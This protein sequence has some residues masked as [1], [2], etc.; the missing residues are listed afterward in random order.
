MTIGLWGY[1]GNRHSVVN[2]L[3][4][5][6]VNLI[7][8]NILFSYLSRISTDVSLSIVWTRLIWVT[9]SLLIPAFYFFAAYFP[10]KAKVHWIFGALFTFVGLMF[11]YLSMFTNYFVSGVTI[12]AWGTQAVSGPGM[13]VFY[14]ALIT[15]VVSS[16]CMIVLK[17]FKSSQKEKR[18]IIYPIYG[19]ALFVAGNV[20][21]G[22]LLPAFLNNSKFLS[23]ADYSVLFF[24]GFTAYAIVKVRL[25]DVRFAIIR[26]VTYSLV[27]A[28]LALIYLVIAFI[29]S[30]IFNNETTS[31][32]Q[33][34]SNLSTSI[35]LAFLI[36]P[37]KRFFDKLT[38]KIFYKDR[39]HTD[40]F[41]SRLNDA[42]TLNTDLRGI[43]K[44]ASHVIASTLKCEQVFFFINTDEG[45]YVSEG[46]PHHKQLPKR[47]AEK[48]SQFCGGDYHAI[49]CSLL[50]PGNE[51][52][53][54]LERYGIEIVLPL[55]QADK[56]VGYLCLGTNLASGY[57]TRDIRV[58]NMVAD[59]MVIAVQ[60]ALAVQKI[61]ELNSTLKQ[62]INDAT[63]ELRTKNAQLKKL[64]KAKDEFVSVAAHELRTP[65]TVFRG[66]ISLLQRKGLG[67][68]TDK[69][70]EVLEKMNVN[71]KNL[72]DL[73]N[74]ML[75]LSKLEANKLVME[76]SDNSMSDLINKSL[77]KISLLYET[78]GVSLKYETE[79]DAR[80]HT[81]AEKFQRVLVN[82]LS[83]AYKFTPAGGSVTV[84]SKINEHDNLVTFCV[85]DTGIGMPADAIGKLFKKFTQVDNYL[86][87]TSGGTGL[88]LS[89]CKQMVEKMDG[90]IWVESLPGE[91]SQFYFTMPMSGAPK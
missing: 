47:D 8:L 77:E 83:N 85:S 18:Q 68:V 22:I 84:S 37:L 14:T 40:D 38:D 70:Q 42:L 74:N 34:I 87:K 27:L 61:L 52:K 76:F 53:N 19:I 75:D 26:S 59:E 62:R 48:I 65:M 33:T 57:T 81:D 58:L 43:L 17:Y 82:L 1:L 44:R 28:T 10:S 35:F 78:K 41:Y 9:A 71:T 89:I 69:Q 66:F 45:H 91:G 51:L 30:L 13:N 56:I 73:V 24:I 5:V 15:A 54:M 79:S 21:F 36:Q 31:T 63:K 11:A 90:K 46:T 20:I 6:F 32:W 80:I 88:G 23:L 64:D 67:P 50:G 3:F 2:Q 86:Q 72:I 55:T 12:E 29:L 49:A 4:F 25:F 7:L 16:F 39:Y 60:N